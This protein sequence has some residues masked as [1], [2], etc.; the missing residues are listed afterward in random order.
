MT[1]VTSQQRRSAAWA[2]GDVPAGLVVPARRSKVRRARTLLAMA[3]SPGLAL[4]MLTPALQADAASVTAAS[5]SGSSGTT[6]VGGVTYAKQGGA[7]TLNVTTSNDTQCVVV[8]GAHSGT[9]TS[10]SPQSAWSF[11][12]TAGAG[13][14][15]RTVTVTGGCCVSQA[16]SWTGR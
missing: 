12:L 1:S 7:L 11:G 4:G 10:R 14:G 16:A 13:D 9:Q 5:F 2:S 15:V 6:T 3:T 8:S